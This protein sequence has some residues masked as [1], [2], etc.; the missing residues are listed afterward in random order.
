MDGKA[1]LLEVIKEA[2]KDEMMQKTKNTILLNISYEVLIE[3]IMQ[4][5]DTV[6]WEQLQALYVAKT[7]NDHLYMLKRVF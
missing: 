6:L 5:D 3:V 7:L 2:N 1:R 4:K